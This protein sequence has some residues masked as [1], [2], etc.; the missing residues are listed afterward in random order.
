MC[1]FNPQRVTLFI[2]ACVL[3]QDACLYIML[4]ETEFSALCMLCK[5]SSTD[6]NPHPAFALLTR[7]HQIAQVNL[8]LTLS[9]R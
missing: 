9:L 6:R 2:Q 1:A 5:T 4:A 7:S 3:T 8:E